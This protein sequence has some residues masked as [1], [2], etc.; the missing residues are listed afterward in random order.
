M[1]EWLE[2]NTHLQGNATYD[3][4]YNDVEKILEDGIV[5]KEEQEYLIK[6]L[7]KPVVDSKS[8]MRIDYIKKMIKNHHNIGIELIELIDDETMIQ[9]IHDSAIKELRRILRGYAGFGSADTEI[10]FMVFF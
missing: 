4:I 8:N 9:K 1:E 10:I 7:S 2:N 3:S 6:I 5:T